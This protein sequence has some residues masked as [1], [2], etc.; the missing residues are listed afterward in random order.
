M[1]N[2]NVQ[3]FRRLELKDIATKYRNIFLDK[4]IANVLDLNRHE[5]IKKVDPKFTRP[6]Q[7]GQPV[8]VND[9]IKGHK[10]GIMSA[11]SY[12]DYLDKVIVA[13]EKGDDAF[14]KE[15]YNEDYLKAIPVDMV[16]PNVEDGGPSENGQ[17]KKGKK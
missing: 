6:N 11:K 2:D 8:S 16:F 12:L 9:I 14:Y 5:E 13:I 7:M 17:I 1:S 4:L 10:E 15:F 3:T